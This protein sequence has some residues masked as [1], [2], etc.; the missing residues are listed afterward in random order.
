MVFLVGKNY[1]QFFWAHINRNTNFLNIF[2]S[3]FPHELKN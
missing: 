3:Q 2:N 1:L